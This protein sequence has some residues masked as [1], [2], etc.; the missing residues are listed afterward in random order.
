MA[1]QT[2]TSLEPDY[3][4][5]NF[6]GYRA[7]YYIDRN[8]LKLEPGEWVLLQVER[9]RDMGQILS[10]IRKKDFDL[11]SQHK[12]PLEILRRADKSDR[13]YMEV[14]RK[15]ED[16]VLLIC[17]EYVD[18]RGLDMKLV[19]AEYQ[20]DGNK[21]TIYF[22]AD[23]RVDFREL[24]K[25]LAATYR[26]RIELRQI[27]VRD[28]VKRFGGIGPCGL[29]TCCSRFLRKF[30][31]ISTQMA[32]Q[33]NLAVNPSKISG[34]CERLMCCLAFETEYYQEKC[35]HFPEPGE[36]YETV[37]GKRI[38]VEK[39]D[40]FHDKILVKSIED[41]EFI[42]LRLIEFKKKLPQRKE[43]LKKWLNK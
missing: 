21:L 32:R 5:V 4:I 41:D 29:P 12:Y 18:F 9:G 26:T 10:S 25:D 7:D 11:H 36:I 14:L 28:E 20:F 6:K 13:E 15:N 23:E 1:E 35:E 40:Y 43:F 3:Y 42:T 37:D 17:Q 30:E 16:E 34:L 27:G 2:N 38:L 24:V 33:Q 39:T 22:T 19:D 8:H 31:P